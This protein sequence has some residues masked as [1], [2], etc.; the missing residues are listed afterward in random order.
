MLRL[1]VFSL[2]DKEFLKIKTIATFY[3]FCEI[4]T[5]QIQSTQNRKSNSL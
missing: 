3:L 1:N 2:K 5:T 4:K